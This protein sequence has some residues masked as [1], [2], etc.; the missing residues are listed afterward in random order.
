MGYD[1]IYLGWHQFSQY[2]NGLKTLGIE[3]KILNSTVRIPQGIHKDY[4]DDRKET[5]NTRKKLRKASYLTP[6]G[7]KMIV[8]EWLAVDWQDCD[9]ISVIGLLVYQEGFRPNVAIQ[10][11]PH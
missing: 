4:E 5:P 3:I 7:T 8:E 9:G 6:E 11:I 1:H 2:C 10:K